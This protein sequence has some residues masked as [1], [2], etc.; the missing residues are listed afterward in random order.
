MFGVM[1]FL[2]LCATGGMLLLAPWLCHVRTAA[3][4]DVGLGGARS[5][6]PGRR[7]K[8]EHYSRLQH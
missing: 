1:V 3:P 7:S 8:R 5:R 4:V 2:L 6:S